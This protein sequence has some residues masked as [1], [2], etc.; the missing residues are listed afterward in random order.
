MDATAFNVLNRVCSHCRKYHIMLLISEIKNAPLELMKKN[1]FYYKLGSERFLDTF[2]EA[3][4]L[5]N[6]IIEL[7]VA[8]V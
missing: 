3:L 7:K 2:E 5:S 6:E 4:D 8:R 1:G